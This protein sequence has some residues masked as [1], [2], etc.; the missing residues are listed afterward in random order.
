MALGLP[1]C[2]FR[3]LGW[4][5]ANPVLAPMLGSFFFFF[6]SSSFWSHK[7]L[8]YNM[9]FPYRLPFVWLKATYCRGIGYFLYG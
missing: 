4:T 9:Y 6:L 8:K 2:S 5:G 3:K 7:L 1:L